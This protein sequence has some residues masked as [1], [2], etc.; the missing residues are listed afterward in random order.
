MLALDGGLY[1][2]KLSEVGIDGGGGSGRK[3]AF[4]GIQ[5]QG[6]KKIRV[7]W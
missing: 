5:S 3:S 2:R 7:L 4:F 6:S 1:R